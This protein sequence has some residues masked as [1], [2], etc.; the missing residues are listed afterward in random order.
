MTPPFDLDG[1]PE[2]LRPMLPR[3]WEGSNF[4]AD[5]CLRHP[6]WLAW[7]ARSGRLHERADATWLAGMLAESIPIDADDQVFL[8]GLRRFRRRQLARIAWRDLA[9]LADVDAVLEEL[10]LLADACITT[11]CAHADR[12]LAAR[13]GAPRRGDG[14]V[15][16]LL[17]L[18][19][20]KLGG[21]ELNFS[22]D[23]DLVLLFAEHGETDGRRPLSHEEYFNRL[24]R[25][26][27]QLLGTVTHEGFVYRVDLR[28]RPFGESGPLVISF[29]AFE[30][31]LQQHG[32]DWERYAY[33][34]A[35]PIAGAERFDELYRNVLRPF[36]Y[37]RYLD[38]GVF[39]SLRGMKELI[40]REVER[41]ELQGQHQ[42]GPGWDPRDR[43]HRAGLPAHPRRERSAAPGPW[44]ARLRY[45]C[46]PATSCCRQRPL[47]ISQRR[48]ATC[49]AWR[50]ACS[51]GTTSRHTSCRRSRR[52]EPGSPR[53][54]APHRG[55]T[56][57]PSSLAIATV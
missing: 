13:H 48:T 35:R 38:F 8:D 54:W 26:V 10:S 41:R 6:D 15:L 45:R 24:G 18:G 57:R 7:L 21:G 9:G 52:S 44:S 27:A 23:I 1:A 4:V 53:R 14:S 56:S 22:S 51:N 12:E 17:V 39:D 46:S 11:A 31:Y 32:R 33:V 30:D 49:A 2:S 16:R 55:T 36:V 50:T 43:V 29:G 3:V 34:K 47:P 5:T 20:G 28:L 37:R 19:M 25:R 42:A 40:A